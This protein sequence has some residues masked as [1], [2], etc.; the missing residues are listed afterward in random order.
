MQLWSESTLIEKCLAGEAT[1]WDQLFDRHY[2]AA[3]HFIFQAGPDLAREDVE[4]ICQETFL[5]VIRN[6]RGFRAGSQL[7]TWIFRIAA[8][9]TRDHRERLKA[10]KRGGGRA[11]L[12]LQAED[13]RTGLML[14]PPSPTPT[15]DRQLLEQEDGL[16]IRDALDALGDPCRE[17]LELR[18]FADRSY[19]EISETLELN[20][21]TVSSRLSKCLDKLEEIARSRA[22]R[23]K[24][25]RSPV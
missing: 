22:A 17:I 12:S 18:Y 20:A 13:E 1:A 21:K 6:L 25:A 10:A 5:A 8:N 15:P 7:Q 11:P 23:E 14:D 2:A 4:E 16:I 24:N 19:E 9:K 3:G